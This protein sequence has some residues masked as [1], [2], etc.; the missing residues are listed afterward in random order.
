M[1][2]YII[3]HPEFDPYEYASGRDAFKFICDQR[4]TKGV[5][6]FLNLQS[7]DPNESSRYKNYT[8]QE[9]KKPVW[10]NVF[11]FV[12]LKSGRYLA[13]LIFNHP[14]IDINSPDKDGK[15]LMEH[16][17]TISNQ[18]DTFKVL[19]EQKNLD[20]NFVNN[21]GKTILEELLGDMRDSDFL[22]EKNQHY[23]ELLVDKIIEKSPELLENYCKKISDLN[24]QTSYTKFALTTLRHV[25][26]D[27]SLKIKK[28]SLKTLKL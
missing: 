3:N 14:K 20:I 22:K 17:L 16:H 25:M 18:Y 13:N 23:L 27:N 28:S 6:A 15:R 2:L 11:N 9:I 4:N 1:G 19:L 5:K 12:E 21:D 8:D 7:F 24:V 10:W 26:L